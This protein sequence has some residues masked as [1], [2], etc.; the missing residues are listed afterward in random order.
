MRTKGGKAKVFL[1]KIVKIAKVSLH[2]CN[3]QNNF[4]VGLSYTSRQL[5]TP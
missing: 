1:K 5:D 3:L 2:T 4:L